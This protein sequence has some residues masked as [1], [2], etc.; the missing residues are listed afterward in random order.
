MLH[1]SKLPT[2]ET[3]SCTF[4]ISQ[5]DALVRQAVLQLYSGHPPDPHLINFRAVK[6]AVVVERSTKQLRER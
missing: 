6:A 4:S 5:E 3:S 1:A 2:G